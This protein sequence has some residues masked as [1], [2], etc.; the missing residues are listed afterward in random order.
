LHG[1]DATVDGED[2]VHLTG[3]TRKRFAGQSIPLVESRRQMCGR[4]RSEL[5]KK[6]DGERGG[7]DA[8][9]VVVTV[10]ADARAAVGRGADRSDG[11]GRVAEPERIVAGHGA[12]EERARRGRVGI[13]AADEHRGRRPADPE[14]VRED[15]CVPS[16]ARRKLPGGVLHWTNEGTEETGRRWR[17][18][19]AYASIA[20]GAEDRR[21]LAP[22]R[23]HRL[24]RRACL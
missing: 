5:F 13:A 4:P 19:P 14:L 17:E 23:R 16:V 2:E 21:R 7:A 8:V 24:H 3:Q 10:H 1:R 12:L 9:G 22:R 6:E 18:F 20:A 15:A 11:G